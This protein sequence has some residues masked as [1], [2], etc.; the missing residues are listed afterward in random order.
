M[1]KSNEHCLDSSDTKRDV[2]VLFSSERPNQFS[3]HHVPLSCAFGPHAFVWICKVL[4]CMRYGWRWAA[5]T[6][7]LIHL[8]RPRPAHPTQQDGNTTHPSPSARC[9]ACSPLN[10]RH[11]HKPLDQ[12]APLP[13]PTTTRQKYAASGNW[14][15][16][17][18]V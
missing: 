6:P 13:A 3:F 9:D 16:S 10:S 2:V 17:S 12:S 15:D 11:H 5:W 1:K 14:A 4:S 8:P 18:A 7:S